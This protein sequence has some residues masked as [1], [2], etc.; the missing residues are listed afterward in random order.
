M[1]EPCQKPMQLHTK[2]LFFTAKK[3]TL[4]FRSKP[5]IL[6]PKSLVFIMEMHLENELQRFY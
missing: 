4:S 2:I 5:G 6:R 3:N 1:A